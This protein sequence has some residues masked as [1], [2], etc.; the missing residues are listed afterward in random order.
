MLVPLGYLW[1][2]SLQ[3]DTY[4][5]LD[6]GTVDPGGGPAISHEKHTTSVT[7]L[8][9]DPSRPADV[10]VD[11]TAAMSDD[12]YTVNGTSP[13][14]TIRATQGQLVEVR[15]ANSNVADGVTL[16]WHGVDVPNAEDGVAG[17]TQDAVLPG[18]SF[19]YRFIAE[20]AGTYWYHSHQ[21]SH[22]QVQGGLLG[23]L[24]IDPPGDPLDDFVA[25]AHTYDG[26]RTI[27][28]SR[29]D[30]KSAPGERIRIINTDSSTLDVW[31]SSP[32]RVLAIDGRDLFAPDPVTDQRLRIPAGGR[33]DIEVS[34][35]GARLQ[36]GAA[37]A[38][39]VGDAPARAVRPAKLLDLMTYGSAH[40]TGRLG[41]PDRTFDY[42]IGR[43]PGFLDGVPGL[44]WTVNG[45][46][47][48]DVPMFMV[49][50]NDVVRFDLTNNT[51]EDHP[52]HLHGHHALVT[53]FNGEE[54]TGSPIWVDSLDL[55]P[56]DRATIVFRADNPGIWLDH[57]H[58][59]PHAVDG[60]IA[61]L[62]YEGITTPF[63]IGGKRANEPE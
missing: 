10:R 54:T 14:P 43:R 1:A 9:V 31:S 46:L 59:L 2:A 51:D 24:V 5:V 45:K 62:M 17:V 19:T 60:L 34:G 39:V 7:E 52:M 48:A 40:P 42:A 27:N 6:M 29:A 16:H 38:V 35:S 15:L 23:A 12:H 11:L 63:L 41:A 25:I 44:W 20:D 61:H 13:G 21:V 3:P 22:Q 8:R 33:A 47:G 50:H 53:A 30:Q 4:S 28:G 57:C 36:I 18:R 58:N 49:R 56:G 26:V 37:T 32:Y 55:A